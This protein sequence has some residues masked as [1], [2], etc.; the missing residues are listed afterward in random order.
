MY[1]GYACTLETS[2][3]ANGG[4]LAV[5]Q[6]HLAYVLYLGVLQGESNIPLVLVACGRQTWQ[7]EN[8]DNRVDAAVLRG[9]QDLFGCTTIGAHTPKLTVTKEAPPLAACARS[10]GTK[11]KTPSSSYRNVSFPAFEWACLTARSVLHM[12]LTSVQDG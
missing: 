9:N 2:T 5:S 6:K 3:R 7:L 8:R 1:G 10:F 11:P 4:E 12:E